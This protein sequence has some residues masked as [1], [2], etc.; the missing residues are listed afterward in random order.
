[1]KFKILLITTSMISLASAADIQ[2]VGF[3]GGD[4]STETALNV[5]LNGI[6]SA[7]SSIDVLA[8]SFSSK[9]IATA[10]VNAAKRGVKVRIV[11]DNDQNSRAYSAIN[12]TANNSIDSKLNS[13]YQD[14]HNKVMI[15]DG[16]CVET[17]SFN[18]SASAA[19][20]N[21]E[22]AII[23]CDK[24]LAQIYQNQFNRWYSQAQPV[25]KNY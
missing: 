11:A 13:N 6:N 25:N 18:Y 19:N 9:P 22:N 17:G 15:I 2:A 8:Y 24:G 7:K 16:K 21:A 23:I 3:S 1:M 14:F 4:G 5:V 10:L 20:K 12:Y